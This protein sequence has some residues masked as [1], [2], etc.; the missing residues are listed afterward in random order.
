MESINLSS[1]PK[2]DNQSNSNFRSSVTILVHRV[3]MNNFN[4]FANETNNTL[5]Q[6]I[7]EKEIM[8]KNNS[9]ETICENCC[10]WWIAQSIVTIDDEGNNA[11]K[12]KHKVG[13]RNN[14]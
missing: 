6:N 12:Y 7:S 8:G 14:T 11:S 4:L 5:I 9:I 13:I 1:P 3:V 2:S 10:Q